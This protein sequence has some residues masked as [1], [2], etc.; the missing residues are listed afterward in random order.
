[1]PVYVKT[2]RW[3]SCMSAGSSSLRHSARRKNTVAPEMRLSGETYAELGDLGV[4]IS[5]LGA[6]SVLVVS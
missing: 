4:R 3:I 1:M 5:S 6:A 2:P